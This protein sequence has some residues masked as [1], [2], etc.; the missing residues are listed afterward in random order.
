M[1]LIGIREMGKKCN[2]FHHVNRILNIKQYFINHLNQM[3]RALSWN[4]QSHERVMRSE[5]NSLQGTLPNYFMQ[6]I[7]EKKNARSVTLIVK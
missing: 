4:M 5:R 2:I 3:H 7:S 1:R 6:F